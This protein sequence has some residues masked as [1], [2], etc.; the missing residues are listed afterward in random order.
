VRFADA[1]RRLTACIYVDKLPHLAINVRFGLSSQ[2][3]ESMLVSIIMQQ[4][5][6]RVA[7]MAHGG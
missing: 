7:G 2:R 1:A 3:N 5:R 4:R 6:W